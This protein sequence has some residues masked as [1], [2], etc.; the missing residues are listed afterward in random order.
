MAD[1]TE[2]QTRLEQAH[3]DLEKAVDRMDEAL[4]VFRVC[5]DD[6]CDKLQAALNANVSTDELNIIRK[7]ILG[8][9]TELP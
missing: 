2:R 8:T 1:D 7:I 3:N 5:K 9:A 4:Q 6:V